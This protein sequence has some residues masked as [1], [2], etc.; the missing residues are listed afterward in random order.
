MKPALAILPMTLLAACQM[1]QANEAMRGMSVDRMTVARAAF[2]DMGTE[3]LAGMLLLSEDIADSCDDISTHG[4][5][6]TL[7]SS[8]VERLPFSD[9][10]VNQTR[11][12]TA[13]SGFSAR[14]GLM[15]V[16]DTK[17]YC[18]AAKVE[19]KQM[20]PLGSTLMEEVL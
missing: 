18:A 12:E 2:R 13:R 1:D 10:Q 16:G 8:R 6:R 19:M 9:P 3:E 17:A 14:H 11:L 20:T 5:V 7:L 15:G 4:Q